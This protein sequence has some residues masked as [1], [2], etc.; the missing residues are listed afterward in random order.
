MLVSLELEIGSEVNLV[1]L[2]CEVCK[3]SLFCCH[4][5]VVV[6]KCGFD[7][8]MLALVLYCCL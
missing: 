4:G 7:N 1:G 6:W 2:L 8:M 3:F 5:I